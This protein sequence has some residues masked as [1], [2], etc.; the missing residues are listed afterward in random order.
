LDFTGS[1]FDVDQFVVDVLGPLLD[2][3]VEGDLLSS[4][5][6]VFN[7]EDSLESILTGF[8]PVCLT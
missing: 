4:D 6:A 7:P 1:D 2:T 5:I 3:T 8:F